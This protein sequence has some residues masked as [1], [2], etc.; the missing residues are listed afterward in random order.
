MQI[1]SEPGLGFSFA[2]Y[3][4]AL[5]AYRSAGYAV[6]GFDGFLD[7]PQAKHLIMRHDCDNSLE[8]ALRIAEIDADEGCSST[9]FVRVH[10]RGYNL[11]SLPSMQILRRFRELG[12]EVQLHLEGGMPAVLGVDPLVFADRQKMIFEAAMDQE[13]TGIS[14]HE[15]ARM[16]QIDFA[17]VLVDRWGLRYHAYENRFT[18]PTVKYLSDSSGTWR[19]GHFRTWV[20]KVDQLQVLTHPIWWFDQVPQ[21]NY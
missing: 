1:S 17:D 18:T 13:C 2:D 16:G 20:D 5:S 12:H 21:E 19:E 3:R 10:A 4:G 15:P 14:S 11:L 8:Q 9:F 6:T 7:D